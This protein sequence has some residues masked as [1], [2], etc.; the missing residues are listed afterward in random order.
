M[1]KKD[2]V[3]VTA[4]KIVVSSGVDGLLVDIRPQWKG[5]RLIERV[6]RLL[7]VDPSSACQRIFNAAIH[8]LK[9]KII[10]AG[11][12]IAKEAAANHSMGTFS[13]SEDIERLD[14]T[15]TINLSYY[16]GLLTRPEWRKLLRVYD[17]RRDLEHEDDEYEA[18]AED[19]IYTF[20]TCINVVLSKDPI[21]IIKLEEVKDIVEQS[22][23]TVLTGVVLEDY[24]HAPAT[25]QEEILKFLVS[26]SLDL[27]TPDIVRQNSYNALGQI[28]SLT[29][30]KAIINTGQKFFKRRDTLDVL[31]ARVAYQ[32]GIFPYLSKRTKEDFFG[33][34][35]VEMK[36]IGYSFK[37][38]K[39]HG[40]CL[41]QLKEFGGL[42]YCP[43]TLLED[44][45]HWL[46][47]CYIGEPSF[48]QWSGYRDVFF[49]NTGAP[50]VVEII[51][52][53]PHDV[54]EIVSASQKQKEIKRLCKNEYVM[55]RYEEIVD[56]FN[57]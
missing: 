39:E 14:V 44:Y 9:E 52:D 24:A 36:R 30:N 22:E 12:D 6:Q 48:G 57:E 53:C 5:K 7:P 51:Q 28:K 47:L 19:C 27:D 46:V 31:K 42:S 15:R 3:K 40:E 26:Y 8:D 54:S 35:L 41:R 10:H 25:R 45:I 21:E 49:S 1:A 2:I 18:G 34:Y 16:M 55:R 32:S 23:P 50:L 56:I 38:H 33:N 37:S 43:E 11:I 13:K 29:E 20:M 17:I 4:N